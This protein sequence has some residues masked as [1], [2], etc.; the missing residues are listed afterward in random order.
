VSRGAAFGDLDNDGD[1]DIVVSNNNGPVRLLLNETPGSSHW[2][3]IRLEG[4]SAVRDG[5][6]GVVEVQRNGAPALRR[7]AHTDGS[8]LSASDPRVHIGLGSVGAIAG[9]AVEWR[10]G[11][12]ETWPAMPIDRQITLR[13]GTGRRE[14]VSQ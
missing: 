13:Q 6:G 7:R 12:R 1:V 9:L 4:T 5:Q 10:K 2:L 3:S 14:L 8:Y 11:E